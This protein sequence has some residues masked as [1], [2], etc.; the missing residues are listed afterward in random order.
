MKQESRDFSRGRFKHSEVNV[1]TRYFLIQ[2]IDGSYSA[3][4]QDDD[5]CYSVLADNNDWRHVVVVSHAPN[6][7][8]VKLPEW[9]RP[10]EVLNTSRDYL[11]FKNRVDCSPYYRHAPIETIAGGIEDAAKAI[12]G[13]FTE[14][15]ITTEIRM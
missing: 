9:E 1:V 8:W 3:M 5:G 12:A 15:E 2:F 4:A 6:L 14:E 11:E 10:R 7:E 13:L